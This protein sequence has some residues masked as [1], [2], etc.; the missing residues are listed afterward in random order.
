LILTNAV[1]LSQAEKQNLVMLRKKIRHT[2]SHWRWPKYVETCRT[3]YS[4]KW[5]L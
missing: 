2:Y 4:I 5:R 3:L 1:I